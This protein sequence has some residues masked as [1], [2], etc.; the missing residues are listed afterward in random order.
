MKIA[1]YKIESYIANI[2]NEKIAAALIFGPEESVVTNYTQIISKKIVADLSDPFLVT[3]LS[4]ERFALEPSCLA[5]EFYSFSMLGGRKLI[6]IRDLDANINAALKALF[7]EKNLAQKSENFILIQAGDL[8]KSNAARKLAEENH[9]FAAIACY[10]DDE[11][12]IKKFIEIELQKNGVE[13]QP[14]CTQYLY[15]RLGKNRQIIAN[16]IKKIATYLDDADIEIGLI[17]RAIEAQAEISSAEFI[18]NF[19][20]QKYEIAANQLEYLLKNGF[21]AITLIRF[22]NN[23]L[24]KLYQAKVAIE[25]EN[26]GFEEA[27][28]NQKLFFKIEAAFRKNLKATSLELLKY[29]LQG[30]QDLEVQ[31]KTTSTISPKLLLAN[32]LQKSLKN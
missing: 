1:P 19:V 3:H 9:D 25:L 16:E 28:K 5:D 8:D 20:E 23:Y 31:I 11:K 10:E 7:S 4:K 2:G 15:E 26:Q 22:L 27:V 12:T 13:P 29:W 14:E 17:A 21:D 30:L 18:N 32:F 6:L 24:Q